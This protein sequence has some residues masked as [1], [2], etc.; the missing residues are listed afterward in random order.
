MTEKKTSFFMKLLISS[1]EASSKRFISI[2]SMFMFFILISYTTFFSKTIDG[3]I[4]YALVS[5]ILGSSAMTLV[6]NKNDN[7]TNDS[8]NKNNN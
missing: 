4:V 5:L 1:S 7:T 3:N 6:T 2:C 8:S